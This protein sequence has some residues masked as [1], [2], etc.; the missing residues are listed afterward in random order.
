MVAVAPRNLVL[1]S[2][3]IESGGGWVNKL[4]TRSGISGNGEQVEGHAQSGGAAK[5]FGVKRET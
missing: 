4:R 2:L 3:R 1:N 5:T